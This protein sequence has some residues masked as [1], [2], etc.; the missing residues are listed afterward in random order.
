M[1]KHRVDRMKKLH[2][3]DDEGL[4]GFLA[5]RGFAQVE[6]SPLPAG[7]GGVDRGEVE[8]MAGDARADGRQAGRGGPR[9]ALGD[10]GIEPD[11]GHEGSSIREAGECA[12]LPE[13]RRGGLG[14]TPGIV[15]SSSASEG[16][17]PGSLGGSRVVAAR[18]T[19]SMALV[20]RSSWLTSVRTTC[21]RAGAALPLE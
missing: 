21:A 3:D 4:L 10:N 20:R 12:E 5:L 18:S 2:G 14:P 1:F 15:C 7:G 9:A 6:R 8:G 13:Q 16:P 17:T 19:S 11:I